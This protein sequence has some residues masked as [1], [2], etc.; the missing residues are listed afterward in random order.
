MGWVGNML[1]QSCVRKD[2]SRTSIGWVCIGQSSVG[3][4]YIAKVIS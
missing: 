1:M 4:I 2:K 3:F